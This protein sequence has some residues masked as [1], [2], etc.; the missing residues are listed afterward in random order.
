GL[1]GAVEH[2]DLDDLR[3]TDEAVGVEDLVGRPLE[4]GDRSAGRGSDVDFTDP[5]RL[6]D[7][8]G[9][10][11][12]AGDPLQRGGGL[13]L[14]SA[15]RFATEQDLI[16]HGL[17]RGRRSTKRAPADS[18]AGWN[19]SEPR[20]SSARWR[21][22]GRPSPCPTRSAAAGRSTWNRV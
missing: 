7:P 5:R 1:H 19:S 10:G 13:E 16:A 12:Y 14:E 11:E 8:D 17:A 18:A 22:R 20:I 3:G 9:G 6:A 4:V 2:A 15:R 21:E